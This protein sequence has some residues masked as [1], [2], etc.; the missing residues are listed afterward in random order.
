MIRIDGQKRLWIVPPKCASTSVGSHLNL[1]PWHGQRFSG[2]SMIVR[3]PFDRLI[4]AK[5]TVCRDLA[6]LADRY[7]HAPDVVRSDDPHLRPQY[8]F[9]LPFEVDEYIAFED[10]SSR[11][12]GISHRNRGRFR[13]PNWRDY[14]ADWAV[15]E[16]HYEKDFELCRQSL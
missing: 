16:Q 12:P 10:L 3:D 7:I 5:E 13:K 1:S 4:S 14:H 2:V 6:V 11:F 15:L 9:S 8:E